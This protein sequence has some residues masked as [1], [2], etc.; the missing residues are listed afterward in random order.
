MT[1]SEIP[2]QKQLPKT[3]DMLFSHV[4]FSWSVIHSEIVFIQNNY[5]YCVVLSA[6]CVYL[7]IFIEGPWCVFL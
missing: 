6:F 7:V 2:V 4:H 1:I 3:H 5:S